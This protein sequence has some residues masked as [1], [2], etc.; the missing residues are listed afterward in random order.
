R[1]WPP[2][3]PRKAKPAA[4]ILPRR[5]RPLLEL[6]EDRLAPADLVVST[7]SDGGPGSLRQALLDT[8]ASGDP[9]N[10]LRFAIPGGG[11]HTI[12]LGSPLPTITRPVLIDGYT[13]AG[14]RANDLAVGSDAVLTVELN[15]AAAGPNAIG[16]TLAAGSSTVR[17]LVINR[18]G[19]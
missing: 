3:R 5:W 2:H 11:V 7:V 4:G 10:T 6:L 19:T 9:T 16:L 8:N 14:S 17:G 18:F 1:L 12:S 13:Q 15:G